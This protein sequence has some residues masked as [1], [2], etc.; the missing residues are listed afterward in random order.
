V[1]LGS[2]ILFILICLNAGILLAQ[3]GNFHWSYTTPRGEVTDIA[4]DQ[5]GNSVSILNLHFGA[6]GFSPFAFSFLNSGKRNE[7]VKDS[8]N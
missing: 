1:R 6:I 7:K 2:E 3:E 5:H 8:K 4:C